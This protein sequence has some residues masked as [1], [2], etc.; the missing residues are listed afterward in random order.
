MAAATNTS[1]LVVERNSP[2]R[3]SV[4]AT[5][6]VVLIVAALVCFVL[7]AVNVASPRLNLIA[8]G[9]ALWVASVLI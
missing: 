1:V 3:E 9:L 2:G 8:A 4:M 6:D 7:A 5:V